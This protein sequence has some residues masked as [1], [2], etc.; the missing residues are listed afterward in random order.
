MKRFRRDGYLAPLPALSAPDV[1]ILR[2]AVSEHLTDGANAERYELTDD[3]QVRNKGRR[4]GQPEYE[5]IDESPD[6][7]IR[8]LPF[9]FNLWKVDRRFE[10]IAHDARLVGYAATLLDTNDVLLMEDNVVAKMPGAKAV[11]WHQDYSY[12]PLAEPHAVT[13]WIALDDIDPTNG[14]MEVAAGTQAEGERLPVRFMDGSSFMAAERPLVEAV[15]SDP[16]LLG[17][18]V[19]QYELRAG[20]CGVHD[21]LVWHGST[22]NDS[23]EMRCALVI[24]YVAAGTKWLGS[25]R[26]PYDD[27]GCAIGGRLTARHF[28]LAG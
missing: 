28:P 21:A 27:I 9:L 22:P 19:R 15:P 20:E 2:A 10:R 6:P 26:I 5:Y 17:F 11:P 23:D 25:A 13:I 3:V 24:R 4:D 7:V 18:S 8:E 1:H 16:R 14:A 12:W